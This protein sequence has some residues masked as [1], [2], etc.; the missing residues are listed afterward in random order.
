MTKKK[1]AMSNSLSRIFILT[2]FTLLSTL[3]FSQGTTTSSIS[4]T[5]LDI[6]GEPAIG[7]VIKAVHQPTGSVYGSVAQADGN[8]IIPNARIGGPYQI[9]TSYVGFEDFIVENVFLELGSRFNQDITLSNSD[10]SLDAVVIEGISGSAAADNGVATQISTEQI[11]SLP[12]LDRDLN[13]FTRLTPQANTGV[14]GISFAG[15]NNRFNAIYIDGA[16][17]NDVFG[18]AADGT[19]GGQIGISPISVDAIEQIQVVV[20]PYDVKLGGFAGG[21]INAVTRSG[22]NNFEGS[23]YYFL[24]NESL[25]GD[26]NDDR[27]EFLGVD[28]SSLANFSEEV[29]GFRLGGPIVKDKVFFFVNTEIQDNATPRDFTLTGYR[30]DATPQDV[31]ALN[32]FLI[33]TQ[34]YDPGSFTNAPSTL[35]GTKVLGKLDFNINSN[36]KIT[37]RHSY[38]EGNSL[39][40][41]LSS[42]STLRGSNGGVFFPSI[43]NSSALEWNFSNDKLSNNLILGYTSVN[44]NRDPIGERFPFVEIEDG[45]GTIVFGSEQFSTAN[46]LTQDVFTLTN[47]FNIYKGDHTITLGTHNE[48]SSIFNVFLPFNFG[49]YE[50]S[51]LDNFFAGQA[52]RLIR[53]YSTVD[54]P[55]AVGDD[56]INAAADFNTTQLGFYIQDEWIPKNNLTVTAGLRL[57]I[58]FFNDDPGIFEDFATTTRPAIANAGWDII[59]EIENPGEAPSTQFLLSPR[60]GVNWQPENTEGLTLKGGAGIF[61]SRIPF[62]WPGAQYNTNGLVSDFIFVGSPQFQPDVTQQPTDF[63]APSPQGDVNLFVEDFKFPQV[64]RT[65]LGIE[66]TVGNGWNLFADGIYTKTIN[67]VQYQSVNFENEFTTTNDIES[68]R[69]YNSDDEVDSRYDAI[70]VGFNTDEGYT[71]N[72]SGG[73]NK[74]FNNFTGGVFYSYGDANAVNEGTSSQNSSQWR[75]QISDAL[76]RNNPVLGRSDFSAGSRF[77]GTAAYKLD[78]N[79]AQNVSTTFSLFYNGQSGSPFSWVIGGFGGRN[80]ANEGGSTSR[81]RSLFFIPAD[82][83]QI[84]LV[85][86]GDLTAAQQWA[87]LD[88]FIEDDDYLRDNRGQYAEKNSN[89][90]PFESLLDMK[91]IQDFAVNVGDTRH[92]FQFTADIFNVGNLLNSEWGTTWGTNDS[93]AYQQILNF[94]GFN[95]AGSTTY[96]FDDTELGNDRFTPLDIPSRWRAQLGFRYLFN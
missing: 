22:T 4:G 11:E 73:V 93:F 87:L 91:I 35:E 75:G 72:L 27:A 38:T 34:G 77:V 95:A 7:A 31:D 36:N 14:G 12:T 47:N 5:V 63:D 6:D 39:S 3:S 52:D 67:N 30:G 65:S 80:I 21:G 51:S 82:P 10:N 46:L 89:R 37:A 85:D 78:W 60:V 19:N 62:V 92:G 24:Q 9:T 40:P 68:R 53:V 81:N 94:E 49:S 59:N 41:N 76:G 64:F 66:K 16:V 42:S 84:N 70:Y 74:S 1:L 96:T 8:Y 71:Y 79:E 83:S 28:P 33:N 61:T 20:S 23:A 57:D 13:D 90:L 17:N 44:D 54:G 88:A 45:D 43:T 69:I 2:F 58:P 29:Y 26:T 48:F 50:F 18:L 25:A 15:L 56:S 55:D 86:D 32:D